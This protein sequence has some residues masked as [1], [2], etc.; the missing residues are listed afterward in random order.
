MR[1]NTKYDSDFEKI[2]GLSKNNFPWIGENYGNAKQNVLIAGE[3]TYLTEHIDVTQDYYIRKLIEGNGLSQGEWCDTNANVDRR[4]KNLEKIMSVDADDLSNKRAFWSNTAYYNLISE[5][6]ENINLRPHFQKYMDGWNTFFEILHTLKPR[7]CIMNGVESHNHLY[8]RYVND[9]NFSLLKNG[10]AE[11][12]GRTF[13]RKTTLQNKISNEEV[14]LL[15]VHHTSRM[16][17]L[18]D[19]HNFIRREMNS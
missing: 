11:K 17:K 2:N 6:L 13:P 4:H 9:Y 18:D 7:I 16:A 8:E 15:F 14:T 12:I 19:W 10:K 5:P 1:F 3:S